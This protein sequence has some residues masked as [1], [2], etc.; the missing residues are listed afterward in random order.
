MTQKIF[1]NEST[2][3]TVPFTD[4]SLYTKSHVRQQNSE[5]EVPRTEIVQ[6][7][8]SVVILQLLS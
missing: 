1:V 8:Q 3:V 2:E 4:C 5:S 6:R 7:T